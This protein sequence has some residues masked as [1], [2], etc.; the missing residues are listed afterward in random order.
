[1]PLLDDLLG[2]ARL[3]VRHALGE[4]Q[5]VPDLRP[6][7][8]AC[9]PSGATRAS[10]TP[11]FLEELQH[12]VYAKDTL[13]HVAAAAYDVA[14]ARALLEAGADVRARNRRGAEP[15]HYAADGGPTHRLWNPTAQA[16][17]VTTLLEAG[18][19]PNALDQSGVAPLH[20]A[21]R[22]RST[23]AVRA[24][25]VG[26]ADPML[27]NKQ[28]STPMDLA[29]QTTGRGGTGTPE[30]KHEQAAIIRLLTE[31]SPPRSRAKKRP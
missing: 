3:I 29:V 26:G 5:V 27:P 13:L 25:L 14:V 23:G 7:A 18:A 17:M 20:R 11:W 30:A 9:F 24:L 31:A 2:A 6:L 21:V 15:L 1:M 22:T 28:G 8:R 4:V 16:A 10:A 19:A 12:Y